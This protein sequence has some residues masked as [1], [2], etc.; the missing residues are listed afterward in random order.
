MPPFRLPALPCLCALLLAP[1][2]ALPAPP[3]ASDFARRMEISNAQMSEDGRYVSFLTPSKD[4]YFDLNV[5]EID[6]KESKKLSLG[7]MEVWD[8]WWI[9]GSRLVIL[10]VSGGIKVYDAERN[11]VIGTVADSYE[12]TYISNLRR[13][14]KL[15]VVRYYEA[16]G[17]RSG[18]A[19]INS[20][21]PVRRNNVKEWIEI[22]DGEHHG[23]WVDGEG[24]VRLVTI[25]S[26]DKQFQFHYRP[27]PQA[28]WVQLPFSYES[29]EVLGFSDDP[30]T[31]FIA[32]YSKESHSSRLHRY[33]VSTRDFG[34]P[35]FEDP[36]YSMSLATLRRVRQP[37]GRYRTLALSYHRDLLAQRA[38]DPMFAELQAAINAKLPGRLNIIWD[39]DYHI[40]RC[41]VASSNGREPARFAV[42]DHADGSFLPLPAPAPWLKPAEM[43]VKRPIKFTARDGLV[44][45]GYLSLP[46]PSANG[47]KPPLVV[48]PHGG[49]SVRDTWGFESDVQ[50]LT[51]RGYAVF[52]PNYRGSPGYS[53]AVSKDDEWEFRKMHNDVTDGVR[54]V[55]GLGV[56][57]PKRIAIFGGSFG[58]YLTLAGLAFEPDLY[59]CGITFAGVFNWEQLLRQSRMNRRYNRF[60]YDLLL[61]K[62]GDPKKQQERFESISP[63]AHVAAIK[64]PVFVI[65]GKLDFNVEYEQS[66]KLLSELKR[67]KVPHEKLFFETEFHGFTDR[68][69][70]QKFLEAVERFLD[71]N[72]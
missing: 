7:G 26:K 69:N 72:L 66:T 55:V 62:L 53:R 40:R 21:S 20:A 23:T 24:E 2:T 43:S 61:D 35:I 6:T 25:Y 58:G 10:Y 15:F 27:T 11:A 45:E 5:Y 32:H 59:R 9:A 8:Y 18:L 64:A 19:V 70:R 41:V 38:I 17:H 68:K 49:P 3:P 29:T 42:Y 13:D 36:D 28:P 31:I 4:D 46:P 14:P 22:P 52:Q 60:N 1:L 12:S 44:L 34:P 39:I 48:Y 54:H 30:D 50:F 71:K 37:D 57:D 16:S 47:E 63:I 33:R 51:T 67:N 65:H 56:V